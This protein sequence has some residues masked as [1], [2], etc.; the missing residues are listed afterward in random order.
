MK[1]E[2]EKRVYST[3]DVRE[4]KKTDDVIR[5][6]IYDK[7][8]STFGPRSFLTAS[9]IAHAWGVTLDALAKWDIYP[10]FKRGREAFYYLKEVVEFRE[11]IDGQPKLNP[12]QEKALLDRAKRERE[13]I[14]LA[15]LRGEVVEIEAIANAFQTELVNLRQRL[16]SLPSKLAKPLAGVDDPAEIQDIIFKSI[17]EALHETVEFVEE[18]SK[19]VTLEGDGQGAE[20][21]AEVDG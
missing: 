14:N 2:K 15:K 4:M 9:A 21:A 16:F 10:V 20:T 18:Q 19:K 11:G 7:Q 12:Q 13:E 5:E 8:M 3:S 6:D 1:E 17:E